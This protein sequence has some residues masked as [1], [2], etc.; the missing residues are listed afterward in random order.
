MTPLVFL[1]AGV[2]VPS[3]LPK[4][5]DLTQRIF[6]PREG[7]TAEIKRV[8][9]FLNLVREYDTADISRVGPYESGGGLKTSGAIYR[10]NAS[11]YEDLFFL[12]QQINLW[13]TGLA[14]HS[15]TTAFM[16]TIERSAGD[17]LTGS[18]LDARIHEL[19]RLGRQACD[20]I[21]AVVAVTLQRTYQE[22]L[23]LRELS[24]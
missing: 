12:C 18:T 17:I 16:E 22:G 23:N 8:R 10:S 2:S 19:G 3:G 14:D 6:E 5:S 21:E 11:T 4:A 24:P 7:E 15:Q 9:A 20:F 1:G 13:S